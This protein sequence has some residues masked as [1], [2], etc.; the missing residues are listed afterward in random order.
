MD[1]RQPLPFVQAEYTPSAPPVKHKRQFANLRKLAYHA[2]VHTDTSPTSPGQFLEGLLSQR[3]WTQR[4]LAAVMGM[5]ET[6]ISK[7][8]TNKKPISAELALALENAFSIPAERFLGLQKDYELANA[9]RAAKPNPA[10]QQLAQLIGALPIPEMI[11]RGWLDVPDVRDT[12]KLEAELIKFFNA[13]S[14]ADIRRL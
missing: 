9:R 4:V 10:A 14:L 2:V 12:A 3:G 11:K 8:I 1:G 6:G 5:E 7:M 13:T